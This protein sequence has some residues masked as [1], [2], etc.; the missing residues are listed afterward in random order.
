L[1]RTATL[2]PA[3]LVD[4][5]V[6]EGQPRVVLKISVAGGVVSVDLAG[7]SACKAIATIR[8]V[9]VE[10]CV[11]LVQ[12]KFDLVA[13]CVVEAGLVVQLRPAPALAA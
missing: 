10:G 7:K 6:P 5:R 1:P 2:N 11:A 12:G 13:L 3:E 9:G 8:E 4:L